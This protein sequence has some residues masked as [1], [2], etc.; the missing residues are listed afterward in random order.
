MC[1]YRISQR[2]WRIVSFTT[3]QAALQ[4]LPS[5][6]LRRRIHSLAARSR[7]GPRISY[8]STETLVASTSAASVSVSAAT[9]RVSVLS[10][11]PLEKRD[12]F[13]PIDRVQSKILQWHIQWGL[14]IKRHQPLPRFE[15]DRA[16]SIRFSRRLF[17]LISAA[18]SSNTSQRAIFV[19][20][21][22]RCFRANA[23]NTRNIVRG[24]T[25]QGLQIDHL[26]R[27][28]PPNFSRTSSTPTFLSFIGVIHD[29]PG[30]RPI[31]SD[32]CLKKRWSRH[33]PLLL[34]AGH[35]LQSDHPPHSPLF[36]YRAD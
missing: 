27:A 11:Q 1:R 21:L 30:D 25:S 22:C 34:L 18:R 14:F 8:P 15:P 13:G 31:A 24:I 7:S 23:G 36:R 3:P 16:N 19:Q 4:R 9:R 20:Q 17:C 26:F 2:C 32:P 33:H 29:D 10:S 12:Q 28:Q 6:H 35:R 5:D